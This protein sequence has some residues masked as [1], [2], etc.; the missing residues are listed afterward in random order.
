[1]YVYPALANGDNGT[2][3]ASGNGVYVY[4][5]QL[6]Q[7]AFATS[8]IPTVD[9]Q[10]TRAADVASV[11]TLSPWFN[12]AAGTFYAEFDIAGV[13]PAGS[14]NILGDGAAGTSIAY[15]NATF[16][17]VSYNGTSGPTTSNAT[18][19]NTIAKASVA[20]ATN[21]RRAVLNAGTASNQTGDLQAVTKLELGKAFGN[22][23][24]NGHLRRVTFYPRQ[25]TAAEQQTLTTL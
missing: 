3:D 18:S 23:F 5:A 15:L 8:Y 24:L 22:T 7:G 4:G 12:Q 19:A 14:G 10:L 1:V 16:Y 13:A 25:F 17:L 9:S 2:G 11:N 6:E 21:S 20:Y